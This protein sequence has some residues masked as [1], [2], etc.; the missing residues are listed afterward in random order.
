MYPKAD[1]LAQ[2]LRE[3][4]G[5]NFWRR[6]AID[7]PS[8]ALGRPRGPPFLPERARS[9]VALSISMQLLAYLA[10]AG[11]IAL[12]CRTLLYYWSLPAI[13]AQPFLRAVL[14]VEHTGC[15]RDSNGLTNTRTTLTLF[16][17]RLLMWNM[18]YHA[19]HHLFPAVPFHQLPALHR[20]V[21][22]RLG[23]LAAGYPAAGRLVVKSLR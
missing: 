4:T 20:E 11:S 6:R 1:S 18:P 23:N 13:L 16:P 8:L 12:G 22:L 5:L 2:Y 3:M 17:L 14:I 19:E 10:G 21:Q 7:Y 9:R 15:S